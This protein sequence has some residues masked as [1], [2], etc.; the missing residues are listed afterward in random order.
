MDTEKD[1]GFKG[2]IK[3]ND[4]N[5][6]CREG[7]RVL[8]HNGVYELNN[9]FGRSVKVIGLGNNVIFKYVEPDHGDAYFMIGIEPTISIS[10]ENII[11][12]GNAKEHD[13]SHID[14]ICLRG[15]NMKLTITNCVFRQIIGNAVC[16]R[17]WCSSSTRANINQCSFFDVSINKQKYPININVDNCLFKRCGQIEDGG[18][19]NDAIYHPIEFKKDDTASR[20]KCIANTFE[21]VN[22]HPIV[23]HDYDS[24]D[25]I[26]RVCKDKKYLHILKGNVLKGRGNHKGLKFDPNVLYQSY[27]R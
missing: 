24:A 5:A 7:D 13:R 11:M 6:N 15:G 26:Y 25:V 9:S 20:L 21:D 23:I 8:I 3:L 10:F 27:R 14:C 19:W 22:A 1:L 18:K 17:N 4:M 16:A 2:L 12:Y